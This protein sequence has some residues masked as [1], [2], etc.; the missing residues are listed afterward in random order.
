MP[1]VF[2]EQRQHFYLKTQIEK[3]RT[4]PV[5]G[6]SLFAITL[7][8]SQRKIP[9]RA[10]PLHCTAD[11]LQYSAQTIPRRVVSSSV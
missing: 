11:L 6:L 3:S 8:P 4:T 5:S 7:P 1:K 2:Q 10:P 9:P